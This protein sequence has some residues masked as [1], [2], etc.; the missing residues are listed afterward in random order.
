M[1]LSVSCTGAKRIST[2]ASA[3]QGLVV[4]HFKSKEDK[5]A[6]V[7][8]QGKAQGKPYWHG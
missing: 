2:K 1:G 8:G 3:V 6:G 5:K 4:V 7:Q